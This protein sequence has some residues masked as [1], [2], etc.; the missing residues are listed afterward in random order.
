MELREG[1]VKALTQPGPRQQPFSKASCLSWGPG[2][3]PGAQGAV[4][5]T[6][7]PLGS[8]LRR[9]GGWASH[10]L[11]PG[12]WEGSGRPGK[13]SSGKPL[14][15][16]WGHPP[17]PASYQRESQGNTP[18]LPTLRLL[19]RE[20]QAFLGSQR[21]THRRRLPQPGTSSHPAHP[22]SPHSGRSSPAIRR[23]NPRPEA[24]NPKQMPSVL[25]G[26]THPSP[27]QRRPWCWV[28]S[29]ACH[30]PVHPPLRLLGGSRGGGPRLPPTKTATHPGKACPSPGDSSHFWSSQEPVS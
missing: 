21:G 11:P 10:P 3:E 14:P 30:P 25:P 29:G 18:G 16:T 1:P 9:A 13:P 2:Q 26:L 4:P 24:E 15:L 6:S 28:T 7:V 8:G 20:S 27:A 12:L 22:H 17:T 19:R 23:R 5:R